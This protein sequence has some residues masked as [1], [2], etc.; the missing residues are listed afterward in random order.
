MKA[1]TT[2]AWIAAA[3]L[4]VG[5]SAAIAA[6]PEGSWF[7]KPE[8]AVKYRQGVFQVMSQHMG[9]IG[10]MLNGKIKMDPQE[11]EMNA[12]MIEA[13]AAQVP[14]GFVMESQDLPSKAKMELW[15]EMPK[16]KE[17]AAGLEKQSAELSQ[18]ARANDLD[19]LKKAFAATAASC[20]KCHDAYRD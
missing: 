10:G 19:R 9:R 4:M 11:I 6:A 7:A 8:A 15:E 3:A 16:F 14:R 12:K 13:L 17:L 5:A 20:K 18:A 2:Q 1:K